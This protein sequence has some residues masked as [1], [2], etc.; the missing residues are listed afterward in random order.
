MY[1]TFVLLYI[2]IDNDIYNNLIISLLKD[3]KYVLPIK[4]AFFLHKLYALSLIAHT[5]HL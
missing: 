5:V 4:I 2:D 3:L 1:I